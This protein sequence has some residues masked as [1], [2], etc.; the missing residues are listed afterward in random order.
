MNHLCPPPGGH[1]ALVEATDATVVMH[2]VAYWMNFN[3]Y[4]V[5]ALLKTAPHNGVTSH[6]EEWVTIKGIVTDFD[7]LTAPTVTLQYV[8]FVEPAP[9]FGDPPMERFATGTQWY[10]AFQA[11]SIEGSAHNGQ[12][13]TIIENTRN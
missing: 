5:A 13:V 10:S 11:V 7:P 6:R 4:A 3:H 1:L 12:F 8:L 2:A 9:H